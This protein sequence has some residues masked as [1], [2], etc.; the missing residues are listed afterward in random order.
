[1]AIYVSDNRE[2]GNIYVSVN[3]EKKSIVS[4]YINTDNGVKKIFGTSSINENDPYGTAPMEAYSNWNYT[5]DDK[6]NI[7]TL[8]YYTG[9]ETD[10]IV[11]ANYEV[12]G[13][14]YK[15]QIKSNDASGSAAYNVAYMFNGYAKANCKNIKTIKF[16]GSI[17]TRN[18]TNMYGMFMTCSQLTD[19]D[20]GANFDTSNVTNMSGMFSQ[21]S[22]LTS[23][24]V[25]SFDT[26]NVTNM[27]S[28]FSTCGSLTSLDLSSF[29]T[30]K[31]TDMDY[32][33]YNSS[34]L[35][36]IY[37]TEGKWLTKQAT[38]FQMFGGCSK[39]EVIY[40]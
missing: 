29:D 27:N 9:S 26:S 32:M 38:F 34:K 8:N 16:S 21:C 12:N 19:I 15:T 28:L 30:K 35:E 13:K 7:I 5:L 3:G 11:Y 18:I 39:L 1:M 23:L 10:V 40:I 36:A 31:V 22:A 24:D 4:A 33:F 25:G 14:T 6:N 20:F 17:D 37:V 2:V